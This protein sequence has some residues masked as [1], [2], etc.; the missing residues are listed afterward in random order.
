MRLESTL[1]IRRKAEEVW[2]FLTDPLNLPRWDKGVAAVELNETTPP[3]V[4]FEFTTVG[5][6]G[7]GPDRGRMTY[8]V[9]QV[10][11]EAWDCRAGLISRTGNARFVSA[12]EWRQRVQDAPEGSRV[13]ITTEFQVRLRY[14]WLAA[15][16]RIIGR[17]A[18]RKDLV[19]LKEVLENGGPRK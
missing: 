9:T 1:V 13:T 18:L 5:Y 6:P 3:G 19:R 17:S 4:G 12:A 16:L 10:D 7:S 2:N 8:R 15:V 11:L 14:L